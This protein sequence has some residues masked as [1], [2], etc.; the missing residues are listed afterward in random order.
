MILPFSSTEKGGREW[1]VVKTRA[2]RRGAARFLLRAKAPQL[3]PD[4]V[5]PAA[6]LQPLGLLLAREL[7]GPAPAARGIALL[8]DQDNPPP[9]LEALPLLLALEPVERLLQAI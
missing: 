3:F 7:R 1:R 6:L 8:L 4:A 2:A 9:G 5:E